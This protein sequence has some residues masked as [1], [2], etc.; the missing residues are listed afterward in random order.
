MK[1]TSTLTDL[2]EVQSHK[3]TSFFL[4]FKGTALYF[5]CFLGHNPNSLEGNSI[6]LIE[7]ASEQALI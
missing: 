1:E 2:A 7:L 5:I 4:L 6:L 3:P